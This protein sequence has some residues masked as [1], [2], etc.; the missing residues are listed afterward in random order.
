MEKI[1]VLIAGIGGASLGTEIFKCLKLA[2]VYEIYGCDISNYAFGHYM[3]GF[4]E[5]FVVQKENYIEQV[6]ELCRKK[7]IE[8]IVPGAEETTVILGLNRGIFEREGIKVACNSENVIKICSS[9][10]SLFSKLSELGIK[11]PKTLLV[12]NLDRDI[13]ALDD[14]PF[15]CVIKPSEGSGGSVFTFLA[16]NK[17][18]AMLFIEYLLSNSIRPVVQE[19]IP[20]SEGEFTIGVLSGKDKKIIGSIVMKRLYPSKLSVKLK[21]DYGIISSGY[22]QGY[23]ADFEDVREQAEKISLSLMSEGPMNI[24]GRLKD[25]FFLP[26]EINPRFSASVYARALAGFNEVHLFIEHLYGKISG[27]YDFDVKK[28][29]FLRSFTEVFVGEDKIKE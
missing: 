2:G 18:E 21:T 12:E 27:R 22:S 26:F 19:Y 9:K 7:S 5:T 4:K 8:V 6:L 17:K 10:H 3:Q 16:K 29:L 28:G 15:P 25:G 23:F 13:S 14:F 20:E 24:Q 11:C 1:K